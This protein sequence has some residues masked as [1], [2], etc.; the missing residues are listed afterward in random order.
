[1][2][3]IQGIV[4]LFAFFGVCGVVAPGVVL[5]GQVASHHRTAHNLPSTDS[6]PVRVRILEG[7]NQANRIELKEGTRLRFRFQGAAAVE[8][9]LSRELVIPSAVATGDFDEDGETDLVL[10]YV[11]P[12]GGLLARATAAS[13]LW[14]DQRK[15]FSGSGLDVEWDHPS[16][17]RATVFATLEA[18]DLI[19][20]GDFDADGHYDLAFA[21]RG[22]PTLHYLFGNGQG[23]FPR[24]ASVHLEGRITAMIGGDI[25]RADGLTDAL[26][27]VE[28]D[29][30][31]ALLVF[32]G[33]NGAARSQPEEIPLPESVTALAVGQLDDD[34]PSDFVVAAGRTLY[35]VK[36]C[37]RKLSQPKWVSRAVPSPTV[38]MIPISAP[39]ASLAVG[40]FLPDGEFRSE[41]AVLDEAGTLHILGE[42]SDQVR[43]SEGIASGQLLL[44]ERW[45]SPSPVVAATGAGSQLLAARVSSL[46]GEDLLIVSPADG[47]IRIFSHTAAEQSNR[48]HAEGV[49]SLEWLASLVVGEEIVN[50]L[51]LRLN[52]DALSDLLLLRR[53]E[54][55]PTF[56]MSAAAQAF[57]V[58][59]TA[60]SGPGSLRQAILDANASPGPDVIR[61]AIPG[62]G[63]PTIA[64]RAPLPDITEAV[65]ID[66]T[67]QA[68]GRVEI[69]GA[70]AGL[71]VNGLTVRGGNSVLRGLVINRFNV[72]LV[73]LL[74]GDWLNSGG[75]AI[76]LASSNNL[77][78]GNFLGTDASGRSALGNGLAGVVVTGPQNVIGGT[79]ASA[80][81]VIS[82]NLIAIG[83]ATATA[84][85]NRVQGNYL[86]TDVDGSIAIANS[87][88]VVIL[89]A[90]NNVVGGVTAPERN[91]ISGN[92]KPLPVP[93]LNV[94]GGVAVGNLNSFQGAAGNLIQGNFIGTT[95]TGMAA[96]GN[97][98]PGVFIGEA[99]NNTVGGT[100]RGARNVIA[101]NRGEGVQVYGSNA[102]GNLVQGNL[103]GVAADGTT[104]LGNGA[105]GVLLTASA[106]TTLIGGTADAAGNVI[107]F[108]GGGGVIVQSGTGNSLLSNS[109]FS[110]TGLGID[111]GGDGVTSNDD[112]D[113]DGGANNSQN[114]PTIT[115][116]TFSDSTGTIRGTLGSTSV[117][118][119]RMEVF[120]SATCDPSGFGEGQRLLTTTSIATDAT[121]ATNFFV[122]IPLATTARQFITAT[123][124]TSSGDTSEFS[125]CVELVPIRPAIAV[126]PEALDFGP[127]MVGQT[128]TLGLTVQNVGTA[129][130][131]VTGIVSESFVF[132]LS[133]P[134][135]PLT[136]APQASHS[137]TV[138]YAPPERAEHTG[139]LTITSNDPERPTV[140]VTLR[141]R[142]ARGPDIRLTPDRIDFG[143]V[144]VGESAD[145][146]L[147]IVNDG[148]LPLM[149][150]GVDTTSPQFIVVSLPF[151]LTVNPG[152][153][154]EV[155]L[156]FIPSRE[157]PQSATA[158]IS[159]NDPNRS[160][161][162]V[163]LSGSGE[164]AIRRMTVSPMALEFGPVMVGGSAD[165]TLTLRNTGNATLTV[166]Q[167]TISD[168][169][170][171]F[172]SPPLPVRLSPGT[173]TLATVRFA[174]R[175]RGPQ[176][177]VLTIRSNDTERPS[178]EISLTGEGVLAPA[179]EIA[180]PSLDF[181]AVALDR[182]V[183][184]PLTIRSLTASSVVI[185]AATDNP[186]FQI[187]SPA[188]PFTLTAGGEQVVLVRFAP[189]REGIETGTVTF[190][191]DDAGATRIGVAVTG[192]GIR[193][194]A[195]SVSDV[196]GVAGSVIALPVTL[197]DGTGISALRFTIEF[198]PNILSVPNP[199]AIVRGSAVPADF[200]FSVNA[201]VRGQVTILIL[202]PLR[203]PVPTL[204]SAGGVVALIPLQVAQTVP[205]GSVTTVFI[206]D[207]SASDPEA[208]PLSIQTQ[209]GRVR[210]SNVRPGDVN[211]DG[212]INEQDLIRLIRHLTGESPLTGN[213][214]RAADVNCDGR[215]NEQDAIRLIQYLAGSRPLP[216][217][218]G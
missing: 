136:L 96:L 84:R 72:N 184:R 17:L 19:L 73:R 123:V 89:G 106:S 169:Q 180:P 186:R 214:L 187:S 102:T 160:T 110:N 9:L 150:S 146:M 57:T 52:A 28:R 3:K 193:V 109:I 156:R 171:V 76:V 15:L 79:S 125:N 66:G 90:L 131:L 42:E 165:R 61:F 60:D 91:I 87:G 107:A 198:D 211:L 80:R 185:S 105:A 166:E 55:T 31:S 199:Q 54:S 119:F 170:F 27:A 43:A 183:E 189:V 7:G 97:G 74:G 218:C 140:T 129:P 49:T 25:N 85:Q 116:A 145:R 163:P 51:V 153:R 44:K 179:F 188:L 16:E 59:T 213:G 168:P 212:K 196:D 210:V 181:G 134:F 21:R 13:R 29:K 143:S 37:D 128:K 148:D 142:G 4:P 5:L 10:G 12:G 1:M 176:V 164:A 46:P 23:E 157:G 39:I 104:P 132:T 161:V 70:G 22:S 24:R 81:N 93:S 20:S 208:N 38:E 68:A 45:R 178:I 26:V 162:I 8:A 71:G 117:T 207:V 172:S 121:G 63:I 88:G 48:S 36:G 33:P 192:E 75:S 174:P 101:A 67:T 158:R 137:V 100:S 133:G 200:E 95:A 113:L 64:L 83:I 201:A 69:N 120:S 182:S 35:V 147:V 34:Y 154:Q 195:L 56:V 99:P 175:N 215:V 216:E 82:G 139:R 209:N 108:N 118:S 2:Q 206:S 32:E 167:V 190:T 94:S 141:G 151:P 115:S 122:T 124:T 92:T 126:V 78:E 98:G 18:P 62:S 204:P 177:A 40:D 202:P 217:R 58:T 41:V 191:G 30:G 155:I 53:G 77:V 197:N 47:E 11:A 159:S 152:E 103:I 65:T 114:F 173:E 86:G 130:L 194:R 127:V 149:V 138:R 14:D 50:V 6:H 135:T 111:L 203:F 112:R 205:D 144:I